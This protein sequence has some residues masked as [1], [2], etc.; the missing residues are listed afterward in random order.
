MPIVDPAGIATT[1]RITG[2]PRPQRA[3]RARRGL[4]RLNLLDAR[5]WSHVRLAVDLVVL[6]LAAAAA[7]YGDS[8]LHASSDLWVVVLFPPVVI[9][10]MQARGSGQDRLKASLLEAAGQVV[11]VVSLAAM[12]LIA[13]SSILGEAHPVGVTVR[14]WLYGAVYLG[15]S[16]MMLVS[17]RRHAITT[18]AFSVPTLVVGAGMIGA[19]LVRRLLEDPAYGLRPVGL[20][21]GDPLPAPARFDGYAVPVVG[22]LENLTEAIRTT[23]ARHVILAFSGEPDHLLTGKVRE[24]HRLGVE[25][26]LVP[27]LFES[28]NE[29]TTLDHVG[30]LPLLTLHDVDPRGWQFAIKHAIDW[31]VAVAAVLVMTPVML[32]LAIA[33]K[34]SSPGP[35]L[36]RQ[37]RVGRDGHEF[38]LLKFR[39]MRRPETGGSGRTSRFELPD[40][41]APGGV[42]GVDR[43]TRIG[44]LLRDTSLDELPQLFNV[45]RG[46][47]SLVGPRPERPEYVARFARD[48]VGYEDRHRVRSGI[49]G[50]AQV[51]GLR[52]QTSI[53]DRVEWDNYYILNWSLRLDLRILMLTLAEICRFRE[54]S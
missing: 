49:T 18:A 27:R 40:D 30:G 21:D 16:R 23:G 37:R 35:V 11:G 20:V 41:L 25:V 3:Q 5:T 9:V 52:G 8:G 29:R 45:L 42:E 28:I 36:F 39:T 44:R 4:R 6:Y 34:L 1:E 54:G 12:L 19:H 31:S 51:H 14:L 32:A 15:L 22:G 38:D 2:R 46:D 50:W 53:S 7:F 24:C 17:I 10:L 48:V 43:R 13:A 26:S 47:M 33:I